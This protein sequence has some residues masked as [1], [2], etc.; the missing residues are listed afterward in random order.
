MEQHEKAAIILELQRKCFSVGQLG[1]EL[2]SN[3]LVNEAI[4][5]AIAGLD[6]QTPTSLDEMVL[7]TQQVQQLNLESTVEHA[8]LAVAGKN[9]QKN[10]K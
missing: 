5:D 10:E 1:Q 6:S 3:L 2:K 4:A 9:L 8:V 7:F